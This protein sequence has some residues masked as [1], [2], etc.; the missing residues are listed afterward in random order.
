MS[1]TSVSCQ[2]CTVHRQC[3]CAHA[4]STRRHS[5]ITS[6]NRLCNCS[7]RNLEIH[8]AG[9]SIS[10]PVG[11]IL[12]LFKGFASWYFPPLHPLVLRGGDV[13]T[14]RRQ[15]MRGTDDEARR[16]EF[17]VI[18]VNMQ[19]YEIINTHEPADL[20]WDRRGCA[21]TSDAGERSWCG[22]IDL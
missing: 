13:Q 1:Q 5:F 15:H 16:L 7:A 9:A 19:A 21:K 8:P 12:T 20:K 3:V 17:H 22:W 14:W 10:I 18:I 4:G 6:D 11:T 2:W